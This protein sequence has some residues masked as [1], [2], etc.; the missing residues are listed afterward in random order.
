MTA[1]SAWLDWV[2]RFVEGKYTSAEFPLDPMGLRIGSDS[3]LDMVLVDDAVSPEHARISIAHGTVAIEDLDSASGTYVNGER[4][5]R[6]VLAPGD[7]V[8]IGASTLELVDRS[9]ES[10]RAVAPAK[11]AEYEAGRARGTRAAQDDVREGRA[12]RLTIGLLRGDRG[13]LDA[14]TGLLLASVGCVLDDDSDGFCDGYNDVVRRAIALGHLD[15]QRLA[16]KVTSLAELR[17]R[18]AREPGHE[19]D[20]GASLRTRH[21]L[22]ALTQKSSPW[23][24]SM[25][26]AFVEDASGERRLEAPVSKGA[27]VLLDH[28][29]TTVLVSE[30]E[31]DELATFDLERGVCLQRFRG[32][33]P[34]DPSRRGD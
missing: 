17:E 34:T 33:D 14:R 30:P 31:T 9:R 7:R 8:T 22:L 11:S 18:F 25:R 15:A 1:T 24:E 19:M 27:R 20:V 23:G 3:L 12:R 26:L 21:G 32:R 4:V 13:M 2:L 6:A 10:G 5:R 16:H 29:D 28:D